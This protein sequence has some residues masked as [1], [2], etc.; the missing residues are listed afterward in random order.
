LERNVPMASKYIKI[1]NDQNRFTIDWTLNTLCTYHCSY[2]PPSLHKGSNILKSKNEDPNIIRLFLENLRSQL[3]GRSVH[4]YINGGEPTIS[5]SLETILNFCEESN[6]CAYV[7]TNG[8][9]SLDWWKEYAHKIYKVTISYHPETV[10][11]EEIFE[12]VEFISTKTNVGVFTLMYPPLWD[13]AKNAYERFKLMDRVTISPSRV[14]KRE[15]IGSN[16]VSYDYTNEQL[17]WLANN[18]NV[19]FKNSNFPPPKN[20]YYGNSY[21]DIDGIVSKFDEVEC[22]NNRKNSFVGWQCNMGVDH[23]FIKSTGEIMEA[24]CHQAKQIATI[25]NFEKLNQIGITCNTK[26]CMCTADVLIPKSFNN[27]ISQRSY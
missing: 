11:D 17:E 2:C 25:F 5:P 22:T 19:I 4:I 26:W 3:H 15:I 6:W 13:K 18:S 23:I 9:R 24:T 14:F 10:I 1:F 16:D 27:G 20:N 7:N 21:I 12:K 8:S